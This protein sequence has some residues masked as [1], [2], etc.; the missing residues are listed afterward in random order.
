MA[1][2]VAAGLVSAGALAQQIPTP[3]PCISD[4][5]FKDFDFWL[6]EWEVSDRTTDQIAGTN[7]ISSIEGS[8][9]LEERW[10]SK[11]GSTGMSI[12][13][14]NPISGQWRQIWV[15]AGAYSIDVVGGLNDE[16]S[17]VLE[18]TIF[19]YRRGISQPFRGTWTPNPDGSVRQ[20]FQQAD[21]ESGEWSVW[22]DG[23]YVKVKKAGD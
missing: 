3:S 11:S 10:T 12:N 18:G 5:H 14:Y 8:C 20:Y 6:G 4:P 7:T 15:A 16:G 1:G 17:M 13:Y 9:A 19:Y 22:F 23:L 2:L 21:P